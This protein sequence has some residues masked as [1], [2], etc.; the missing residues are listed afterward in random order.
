MAH[1]NGGDVAR[2]YQGGDM[3]CKW[4]QVTDGFEALGQWETDCGNC[5]EIT[6]GTPEE[7]EMRYCSYCGRELEQVLWKP[8]AIC[9]GCGHDWTADPIPYGKSCCPDYRLSDGQ[10]GR[11][12]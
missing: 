3:K 4:R 10:R 8:H 6:E 12:D 7:N 5:Y 11:D 1:K 2:Y 9:E